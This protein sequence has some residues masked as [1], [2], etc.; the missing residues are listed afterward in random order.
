L[1]FNQ[2]SAPEVFIG[3]RFG[4]EENRNFTLSRHRFKLGENRQKK[5]PLNCARKG[6]KTHRG[7]TPKKKKDHLTSHIGVREKEK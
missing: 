4:E 6:S 3:V 7:K 2:Q 5:A 1:D